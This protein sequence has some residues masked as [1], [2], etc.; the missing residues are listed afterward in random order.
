MYGTNDPAGFIPAMAQ[1]NAGIAASEITLNIE[2]GYAN[3]IFTGDPVIFGY[4]SDGVTSSGYVVNYYDYIFSSAIKTTLFGA[5]G[6]PLLGIFA[7]CSYLSPN[8]SSNPAAPRR[9]YWPAS[10]RTYDGKNPVAYI[11]P[12][13]FDYLFTVQAGP[14]AFDPSMVGKYVRV[15]YNATG[16]LVNGDLRTGTSK[17]FVD[18]STASVYTATTL[19]T[20]TLNTAA[21][22]F[23]IMG[24]DD[25]PNAQ[26]I[27]TPNASAAV[28]YGNVLVRLT[29][30]AIPMV[31]NF[32][33]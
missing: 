7:G 14:T 29:N 31:T 27:Q 6:Y 9:N 22:T 11:T 3:N 20:T 5:G 8:D 30:S 18:L 4:G 17:C 2:N 13:N 26:S 25:K 12:L 1:N 21:D 23:L 10:T 19:A 32:P 24:I 15:G 33:Q 16:N 28:P